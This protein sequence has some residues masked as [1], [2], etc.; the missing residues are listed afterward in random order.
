MKAE[1]EILKQFYMALNQN[2]V[3]AALTLMD[4]DIERYESFSI[5]SPKTFRGLA[6][7]KEHILQGRGPWAEGSCTPLEFVEINGKIFATVKVHVRL[8]NK[9][10]WIEGQVTDV[11]AFKNDKISEMHSFLKQEEAL[12][13]IKAQK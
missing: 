9:Q 1:T 8:K 12:D 11:F 4:P 13:W 2:D 3:Q 10:D 5:P 6:E 7:M